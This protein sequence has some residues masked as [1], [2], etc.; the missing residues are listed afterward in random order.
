MELHWRNAQEID[1][2]QREKAAAQIEKLATH[3][4]DLIDVFVDVEKPSAHHK[5]GARRVEIRCQA[6]GAE[7]VAHG[8][9]DDLALALRD[10]LRTFRREVERL[11]ARR[12]DA[13][14]RAPAR[15][16][17]AGDAGTETTD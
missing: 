10:A 15:T 6:R 8:A 3:H 17:E 4:R 12:R 9:A 14:A 13:R 5:Q 2:A 16:R 1:D 11:R 7:L